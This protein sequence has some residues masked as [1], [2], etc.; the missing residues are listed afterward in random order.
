MARR[1]ENIYKRKDG[2][3]EGR[4][5]V[6]QPCGKIKLHSVY[7]HSYSEIKQKMKALCVPNYSPKAVE[8]TVEYY[9]EQWL[10]AVR[11]R[12]KQSTYSKYSNICKNHI[13]PILG[14]IRM[15]NLCNKDIYNLMSMDEALAPKTLNDIL[16]VL[17]MIYSYAESAGCKGYAQLDEISVR[18]PKSNTDSSD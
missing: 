6:E 11:L 1:G 8:S 12:C 7:A 2:R 17:K 16:C 3:W 5:Q 14:K 15:S 9:T 18:V 13:N 10:Q 4:I